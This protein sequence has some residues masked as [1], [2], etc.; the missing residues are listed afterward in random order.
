MAGL[1]YRKK[2][3][4]ESGM[5][6]RGSRKGWSKQQ[7]GTSMERGGGG[8]ILCRGGNNGQIEKDTAKL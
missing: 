8:G 2:S 4:G 5:D 7:C 1:P 6:R 3:G